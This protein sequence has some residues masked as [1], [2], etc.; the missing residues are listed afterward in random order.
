MTEATLR[1]SELARRAGVTVETLRYY[2]RRGLLPRPPRTPTG[3][4]LYSVSEVALVGFIR[5]ARDLGFSLREVEELLDLT[6]DPAEDCTDICGA[7]EAKLAELD[8][9][10]REIR[11]RKR[12]L[13]ELLRACPGNVPIQSCPIVGRMAGESDFNPAIIRS[14]RRGGERR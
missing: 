4:R 6:A 14:R 12:A 1:S 10:L 2:E 11:A 7:V 13:R 5:R 8:R 9:S 3:Y